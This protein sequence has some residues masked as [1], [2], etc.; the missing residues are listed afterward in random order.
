MRKL[1]FLDFDYEMWKSSLRR[2]KVCA[3]LHDAWHDS[4]DTTRRSSH[5]FAPISNN[6][7]D[8]HGSMLFTLAPEG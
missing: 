4:K 7:Y 6:S 3:R 8:K 1:L 2:A 5:G